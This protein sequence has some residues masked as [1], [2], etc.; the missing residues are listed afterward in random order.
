M[1]IELADAYY[2]WLLISFCIIHDEDYD[3]SFFFYCQKRH[4]RFYERKMPESEEYAIAFCEI[5]GLT[6]RDE[7]DAAPEWLRKKNRDSWSCAR[8]Q[9][10]GLLV[11][12]SSYFARML[13]FHGKSR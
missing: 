4:G 2:R 11:G 10:L 1:S 13:L 9:T 3:E 8:N 6:V 7:L 5:V 12:A